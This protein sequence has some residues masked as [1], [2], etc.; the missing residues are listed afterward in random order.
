[1]LTVSAGGTEGRYGA[2]TKG[3]KP[4]FRDLTFSILI[5]VALVS[6]AH[7]FVWGLTAFPPARAEVTNPGGP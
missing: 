7:V 3:T 1:L 6:A 5:A 4:M 2:L